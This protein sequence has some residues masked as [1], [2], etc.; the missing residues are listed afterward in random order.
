MRFPIK[1]TILLFIAFTLL[2][3]IFN[4]YY[5]FNITK[6]IGR[7]NYNLYIYSTILCILFFLIFYFYILIKTDFTLYTINNIFYNILIMIISTT[8]WIISSYYNIKLLNIF[9]ISI[10]CMSNYNLLYAIINCDE[11]KMILFKKICI[12]MLIYL[13]FHH[14]FIDLFLWNFYEFIDR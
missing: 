9:F 13:L 6:F 12:I 7:V 2:L 4:F 8:L 1:Y 11:E 5:N 14:I 10:I 3:Y